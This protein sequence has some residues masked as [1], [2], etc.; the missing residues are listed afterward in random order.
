MH[1]EELSKPSGQKQP[2]VGEKLQLIF[3]IDPSEIELL[4]LEKRSF[5]KKEI[6]RYLSKFSMHYANILTNHI[7]NKL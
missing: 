6:D 1:I 2:M 3:D 5:I 4:K 7:E